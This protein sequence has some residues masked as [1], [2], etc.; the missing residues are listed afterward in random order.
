MV[1]CFSAAGFWFCFFFFFVAAVGKAFLNISRFF[2]SK[3][4]SCPQFYSLY[5]SMMANRCQTKALCVFFLTCN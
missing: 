5:N 3:Y 4:F 1:W 2:K